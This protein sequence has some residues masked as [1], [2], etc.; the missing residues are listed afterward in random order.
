MNSQRPARPVDT[1]STS[2]R[3]AALTASAASARSATSAAPAAA[4]AAMAQG[5]PS[6]ASA[7]AAPP[8]AELVLRFER[9]LAGEAMRGAVRSAIGSAT[10]SGIGSVIGNEISSAGGSAIGSPIGSAAGISVGMSSAALGDPTVTPHAHDGV[11]ASED[12]QLMADL[13]QAALAALPGF[14]PQHLRLHREAGVGSTGTGVPG[15]PGIGDRPKGLPAQ[16]MTAEAPVTGSGAPAVGATPSSAL[17]PWPG[18]STEFPAPPPA[19]PVDDA[20]P[21]AGGAPGATF[22]ASAESLASRAGSHFTPAGT[23]PL[24]ASGLPGASPAAPDARAEV[25][26]NAGQVGH[27][28]HTAHTAHAGHGGPG[29]PGAPRPEASHALREDEPGAAIPSPA[30]VWPGEGALRALPTAL[31]VEAAPVSRPAEAVWQ[32]VQAMALRMASGTGVTGLHQIRLEIDPRLLPG[33]QVVLQLSA[34]QV[35]VEFTCA[36]EASRRR[37]RTVAQRELGPM[38]ERL[39][40]PVQVTLCAE[41][42]E[43]GDEAEYLHAGA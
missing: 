25:A 8:L 35:Q 16:R 6:E 27:T 20:S 22:A 39:G 42:A 38:A 33:V 37:L 32:Q 21:T 4:A 15:G 17:T 36:S 23:A 26:A 11:L 40:R 9:A 41:G 12:P 1:P 3:S 43:A 31:P 13:M 14:P 5:V 24:P 34:G 2:E 30:G 7:H 28:A 29:A 10:G 18:A 19:I